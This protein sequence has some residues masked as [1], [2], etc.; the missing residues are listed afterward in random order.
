[1]LQSY[2]SINGFDIKID[3]DAPIKELPIQ[4]LDLFI[5]PITTTYFKYP[6]CIVES[7]Q[8]YEKET[9]IKWFGISN[10]DPLTGIIIE[11]GNLNIIPVLNYF[12]MELCLEL[13][14]N[15]LLFH[16]PYGDILN[17][18]TL[19]DEYFHGCTLKKIIEPGISGNYI[20]TSDEKIFTYDLMMAIDDNYVHLNMAD[21]LYKLNVKEI[22]DCTKKPSYQ[23]TYYF[24]NVINNTVLNGIRFDN[25]YRY[26]YINFEDIL[27]NCPITGYSMYNNCIISTCGILMHKKMFNIDFKYSNTNGLYLSG[28]LQLLQTKN[29]VNITT[30][31]NIFE[32]FGKNII[33]NDF[34]LVTT[35][36]RLI[37]DNLFN[38]NSINITDVKNSIDITDVKNYLIKNKILDLQIVKYPSMYYTIKY[39]YFDTKKE[40]K[41]VICNSDQNTYNFF[42]QY[43][44]NIDINI[45]NKLNSMVTV[46][47]IDS[48]KSTIIKMREQFGFPTLHCSEEHIYGNDY[49]FFVLKNMRPIGKYFKLVYFIGSTL[50][51]I[52]FIKCKFTYCKFIATEMQLC[53]FIDCEFSNCTFF[54][55]DSKNIKMLGCVMD[56]I[57]KQTIGELD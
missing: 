39:Q 36:D 8:I 26:G 9:I 17:L 50:K 51:K 32:L 34:D 46:D 49:S 53:H 3:P 44:E 47:N 15:K 12:L 31:N 30:H 41:Y 35:N 37:N 56:N 48:F 19:S 5:D 24:D 38:N 10:K 40:Q 27:F 52:D 25:N 14:D 4:F 28:C 21:Y 23:C 43:K 22:M 1:M 29:I 11:I 54:K 55:T 42:L 13:V 33:E 16:T 45:Q 20:K 57:T 6:V 18:L 7:G 2:K